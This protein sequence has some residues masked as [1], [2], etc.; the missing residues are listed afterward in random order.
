M[1]MSLRRNALLGAIIVLAIVSILIIWQ[2]VTTDYPTH[3]DVFYI[4]LVAGV[5]AGSL[6]IC[7][8]LIGFLVVL[9][10]RSS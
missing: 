1:A 4:G 9:L 6:L 5:L 8:F 10:I 3:S 7:L 2:L